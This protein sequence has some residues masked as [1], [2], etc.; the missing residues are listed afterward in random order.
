MFKSANASLPTLNSMHRF[1]ANT[2]SIKERVAGFRAKR[3]EAMAKRY[4]AKGVKPENI[5]AILGIPPN[6]IDSS[7]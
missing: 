6:K 7:I 1:N 3:V 5:H 2:E 4:L